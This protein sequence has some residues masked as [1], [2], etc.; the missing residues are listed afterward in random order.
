M[1]HSDL[2]A[3][4]ISL[5]VHLFCVHALLSEPLGNTDAPLYFVMGLRPDKS[6]VSQNY[7]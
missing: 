3:V 7:I 5:P 1:F 2:A 6:I 4:N